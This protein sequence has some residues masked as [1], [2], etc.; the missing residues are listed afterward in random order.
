MRA[1]IGSGNSKP[2]SEV[3]AGWLAVLMGLSWLGML[4]HNQVE[5]PQ[6]PILSPEYLLPT[7]MS[8]G[9]FLA[10]YLQAR[11]RPLWSKLII[12]WTGMHLLIGG[13]LSVLPLPVWPFYP[14][15][16]LG[17]YL[18]HLFYTAS[19]VPLIWYLGRSAVGRLMRHRTS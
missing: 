17:H 1:K 10:W 13:I 6:L 2:P 16:S 9:L 15:Q 14:E 12:L 4:V 8:A 5:L 7:L 19:Q 11:F 3:R 18:A